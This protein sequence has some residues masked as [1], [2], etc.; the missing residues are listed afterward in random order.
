VWGDAVEVPGTAALNTGGQSSVKS[1]SCSAAGECEAGG[2]Y[3]SD[4]D[5][6]N[7][8]LVSFHAGQWGDAAG[9]PGLDTLNAGDRGFVNSVSCRASGACAA[10]GSYEDGSGKTHL[11]LV[12][13]RRGHWDTAV[14]VPGMATLNKRDYTTELE[15]LSCGP[16]SACSAGGVYTDASGLAQVFVVT[17]KR[18]TR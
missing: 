10:G 18:V 5:H 2:Y 6:A 16:G 12:R 1:I 14:Q 15:S 8:Y 13:E 11:F 17:G 9:V 4:D 3:Y 7:G